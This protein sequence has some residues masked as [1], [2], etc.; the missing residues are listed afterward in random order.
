MCSSVVKFPLHTPHQEW[1]AKPQASKPQTKAFPIHRKRYFD[2]HQP[3]SNGGTH[4]PSNNNNTPN[5]VSWLSWKQFTCKGWYFAWWFSAPPT[6]YIERWGWATSLRKSTT[7]SWDSS[8]HSNAT[9]SHCDRAG[10]NADVLE[11]YRVSQSDYWT[12]QMVNAK[13][14]GISRGN[15]FWEKEKAPARGGSCLQESSFPWF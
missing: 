2:D 1:I 7:H 9:T 4:Y 11:R 12:I 3:F 5:L 6:S 8:S 15:S 13:K 10:R 14:M